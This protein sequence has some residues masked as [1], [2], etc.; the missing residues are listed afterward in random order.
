MAALC[1]LNDLLFFEA[2]LLQFYLLTGLV[3]KDILTALDMTFH[4]MNLRLEFP[5]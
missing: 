2:Q 3:L 5:Q 4:D 1:V